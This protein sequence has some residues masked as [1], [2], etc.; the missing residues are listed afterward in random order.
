LLSWIHDDNTGRSLKRFKLMTL[1]WSAGN[2]FL[3]LDFVLCAFT[4]WK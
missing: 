3:P 1:G 2:S 4:G